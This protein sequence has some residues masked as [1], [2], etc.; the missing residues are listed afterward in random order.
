MEQRVVDRG[1]AG[2]LARLEN[3]LN[4]CRH[5]VGRLLEFTRAAPPQKAPQD[6]GAVVES[7]GDFFLPAIR[8]KRASLIVDVSQIRGQYVLADRNLLETLLLSL[9]SNA[10]DAVPSGGEIRIIGTAPAP[11]RL[12]FIIKDNGCGF[13]A[14]LQDR[15]FEPFFTTKE[16]GKGTGLGLAIARNVVLEHGGNIRL[17][18]EPG[19]GT[20]A[21]VDLPLAAGEDMAVKVAE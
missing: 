9:L 11:G 12:G 7:V 21:Y 20:A 4:F 3:G 10:L 19:K 6:A 2:D 1:L 16:P 5:F 15:V 17:E 18:S 8:S 13:D 14:A